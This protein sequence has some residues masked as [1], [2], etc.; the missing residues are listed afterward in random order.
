MLVIPV[1]VAVFFLV[2]F[3]LYYAFVPRLLSPKTLKCFPSY[4]FS[5]CPR[6]S[7][8]WLFFF[9]KQPALHPVQCVRV[10]GFDIFGQR[11][12][13]LLAYDHARFPCRFRLVYWYLHHTRMGYAT[14]AVMANREEAMMSGIDVNRVSAFVFCMGLALAAIAGGFQLFYDW[15]SSPSM[16]PEL[17]TVS[18]AI[19][20]LG[21][22]GNPLG[23]ILWGLDLWNRHHVYA[24]LFFLLGRYSALCSAYSRNAL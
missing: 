22:L 23:T 15:R 16:G 12:P 14:R 8:P 24:K 17:T 21:S 19:I 3:P 18:F 1:A 7:R 4:S 11:F 13:D 20:V 9:R 6:L 2:G 5:G 10:H